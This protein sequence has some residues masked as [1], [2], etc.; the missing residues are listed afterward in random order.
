MDRLKILRIIILV[1]FIIL[2]SRAAYLQIIN[3][4]YF[5]RLSEGNRISVRPINAPRGKI[6]DS[7]GKVIVSNRLTY[8]L[9]LMRNEIPP[10]ESSEEILAEL[11]EISGIDYQRL[12]NNYQNTDVK[13]VI[14]PILLARHLSKEEM[15]VIVEN[16][17]LLPGII[18]Q[19]ASLRDYIYPENMVH[20][21][22]YIGEINRNELISFNE[23]GYN[24]RAG[25]F[26]GKSGLERQ[27]E[28]YLAGQEGAEQIEVD[29]RGQK[30]QTLG[31]RKPIAGNDLTL[32]ID[33]ELQLSL[34][35]I[36]KENFDRL[37]LEAEDDEER[38]KPTAAAAIVMDVNS[39]AILASS[40]IP[41]YDLN[42]FAKGISSSDYQ[43]LSND[44]LRPML[45]RTVMSDYPTGSIFKLITGA[46]A[47]EELGVRADSSF[48]D[49]SG[50]FYIPNWS[51]PFRNWLDRG[52]GQLDF[53]KAMARSNNIVFYEL[54][55]ELYK[56]YRGDK[57]AE[58][59]RKFGLDQKTGIDLPSER[60]GLVPDDQWKRE[61]FN[62][63][64]YPGDAVNL[65]IGQSNLLTTPMQIAQLFS[66]FANEGILYKPQ[67][68]DKI[69]SPEGEVV[70]DIE[71]YIKADLRSEINDST[72]AALNQGLYDVVNKSYG[73]ASHHFLN[74]PIEV[75]GKTGT[76][77]TSRA[78]TNHAWFGAFAPYE[79]PQISVVV[80]L[81][82]GGSSSFSVPIARDIIAN[83]FGVD[84]EDE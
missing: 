6:I 20:T 10:G 44:P 8:N 30:K 65:S 18:V 32:N 13:S 71:P 73:T 38:I 26:V 81:E 82:N 15:V 1:I 61:T 70:L 56:E 5:F 21:T 39:G 36:L 16:N 52:E 23:L 69:T 46:A 76:A 28:F 14:E 17:D 50:R 57:L 19:E 63:P 68:A 31:I 79:D 54:G 22:G 55:H 37:R 47:M 12:I 64:W 49:S 43:K 45:D 11:S 67:L 74:F 9:Y 78:L 58:Y 4:D 24:Y 53:V 7:Q 2:I 35:E 59:A 27:Y 72:F 84:E 41:N 48:Y 40:S 66:V 33:F 83:Y 77:Q 25:D 42:L 62:E 80:L 3:G 34:E 60:S 75:A 51:R 29:N